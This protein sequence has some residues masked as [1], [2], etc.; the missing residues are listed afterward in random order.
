MRRQHRT[1]DSSCAI[2][3]VRALSPT[4]GL[5]VDRSELPEGTV[6]DLPANFETTR[7][8]TFIHSKRL[9]FDHDE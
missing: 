8:L 5:V 4:H 3:D 7:V 1:T 9:S 6:D 2:V